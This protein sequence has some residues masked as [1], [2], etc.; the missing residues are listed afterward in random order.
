MKSK[1]EFP[2]LGKRRRD[3]GFHQFFDSKFYFFFTSS[4]SSNS[5]FSN[6]LLL[7]LPSAYTVTIPAHEVLCF[8]EDFTP[9]QVGQKASFLFSVR[10]LPSFPS[11]P[12]SPSYFLTFFLFFFLSLLKIGLLWRFLRHRLRGEGSQAV[13][14]SLWRQGK[15]RRFHLQH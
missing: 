2:F 5:S 15:G 11:F 7:I 12:C 14:D 4:L 1:L 9:N 8:Y 6:S 13:C 3:P 10:L